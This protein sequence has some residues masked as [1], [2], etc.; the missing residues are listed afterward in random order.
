MFRLP[1]RWRH[2]ERSEEPPYLA[3]VSTHL[4]YRPEPLPPHVILSE[5]PERAA[6]E[7]NGAESKD[8]ATAPATDIASPFQPQIQV[9]SR[10]DQ[11]TAWTAPQS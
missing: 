10:R 2:S 9:H 3:D 11:T 5:A 6:G 4:P 7:S 8:P 1:S